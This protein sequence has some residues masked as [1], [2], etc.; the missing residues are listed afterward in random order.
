M[1][2]SFNVAVYPTDPDIA[3]TLGTDVIPIAQLYPTDPD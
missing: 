3:S 1:L 2:K